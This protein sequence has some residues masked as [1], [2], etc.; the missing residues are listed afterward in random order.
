MK[1][2]IITLIM[3]ILLGNYDMISQEKSD[4]TSVVSTSDSTGSSFEMWLIGG[5]GMTTGSIANDWEYNFKNGPAFIAGIEIPLTKSHIW[6]LEISHHTWLCKALVNDNCLNGYYLK[7]SNDTYMQMGISAI[8]KYYIQDSP[9]SFFRASFNLGMLL[10]STIP[11]T[12]DYT[13]VDFGLSLY[14]KI[15]NDISLSLNRKILLTT[16][17]TLG[18]SSFDEPTPSF[19]LLTVNYKL[20]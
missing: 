15:S 20:F 18:H 6:G 14:F 2:L 5:V 4:S 12:H 9:D 8:L 10:G 7:I 19:L 17:F 16:N 11:S 1:T 3:V 13:A